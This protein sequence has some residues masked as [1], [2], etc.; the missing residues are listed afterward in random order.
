MRQELKSKD[1]KLSK[2]LKNYESLKTGFSKLSLI[3]FEYKHDIDTMLQEFNR[4]M[5]NLSRKSQRNQQNYLKKSDQSLS[6]SGPSL[7]K[8]KTQ[9][10]NITSNLWEIVMMITNGIQ[11]SVKA[12]ENIQDYATIFERDYKVKNKFELSHP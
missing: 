2:I 3:M 7:E 10:V 12:T 6:K 11:T 5:E 9:I 8:S 1:E 4:K